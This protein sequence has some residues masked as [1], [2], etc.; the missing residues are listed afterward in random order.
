MMTKKSGEK[1]VVP[2]VK[3]EPEFNYY[4]WLLEHDF[5]GWM[6]AIRKQNGWHYRPGDM[7]LL[8]EARQTPITPW[9]YIKPSEGDCY[10][11]MSVIFGVMAQRAKIQF[12][13]EYCMGCWKVVVRPKTLKQLFALEKLQKEMNLPSKCGIEVRNYV[14]AL[15]GGYFYNRSKEQGQECYEKVREAVNACPELG[16]DI[17]I[18]LKRAC[19]EM[20]QK[21]GETDKWKDVTDEQREIEKTVLSLIAYDPSGQKQPPHFV[22]HVHKTWIEWAFQHGDETYKEYT[23]GLPIEPAAVTYHEEK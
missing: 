9:H 21:F 17:D 15:Y 3:E 20:E 12:V 6:E 4:K 7:K 22:A 5:V 2:E 13:P 18:Y 19:T 8:I 14:P 16:E 11:H 10:L 23:N 1:K